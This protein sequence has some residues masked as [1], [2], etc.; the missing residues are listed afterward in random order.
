MEKQPPPA[1]PT[2]DE[3]A[4]GAI[5][6]LA[7]AHAAL[8]GPQFAVLNVRTPGTPYRYYAAAARHC[9]LLLLEIEQAA[10]GVGLARLAIFSGGAQGH[11]QA[12][13]FRAW[14]RWPPGSCRG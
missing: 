10:A 1:P 14:R 3:L 11:V 2:S 9:C 7:E 4:D 8:S 5:R 13:V 12:A 6:L